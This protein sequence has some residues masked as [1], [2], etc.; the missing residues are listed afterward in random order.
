MNETTIPEGLPDW[1]ANHVRQYF[2]DPEKGHDWDSTPVG[3]PGVLPCLLLFT[4]GRKSGRQSILPL[5][6]GRAGRSVV[7]IASKGGAPSH[8]AWYLNLEAN[9]ECEVQVANDRF[10]AKARTAE[11]EERERLWRQMAEIYPPY[12]EYQ[13][14]A[15][16]RQ[17]PVVVIDPLT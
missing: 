7:V 17:I 11:G 10:A 14:A 15:G 6:Y 9:P 13:V 4:T 8:P 1:I 16:D 5:I 3:G 2:E 12:N